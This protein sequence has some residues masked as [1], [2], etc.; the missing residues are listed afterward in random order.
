M[1]V[2]DGNGEHRHDRHDD[3]RNPRDASEIEMPYEL[4]I[5]LK[6]LPVLEAFHQFG[7]HFPVDVP[8][9][10]EDVAEYELEDPELDQIVGQ[11]IFDAIVVLVDV[12]WPPLGDVLVLQP[13]KYKDV[14][15]GAPVILPQGRVKYFLGKVPLLS[16]GQQA[17]EV[18]NQVA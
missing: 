12:A 11:L 13:K 8:I 10:V 4:V 15:D 5:D 16:I 2:H 9:Q 1:E 14:E 17:E 7:L 18:R 3:L 6:F